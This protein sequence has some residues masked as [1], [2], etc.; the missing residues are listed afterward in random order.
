MTTRTHEGSADDLDH[1]A[2]GDG[3]P[4]HRRPDGRIARFIAEALGTGRNVLHVGAGAGSYENV[5]GTVTAV[6]R[7]MTCRSPTARSPRR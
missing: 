5:A 1:G 7:P 4:T 3:H 6:D 2:I